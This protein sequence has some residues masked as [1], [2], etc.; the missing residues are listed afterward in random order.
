MRALVLGVTGQD[1]SYLVE[2][3]AADGYEVWGMAR[4]PNATASVPLVYGDLLDQDSLEAAL[5]TVR[6]DEIYNLAAVTSPGGA[7]GS[8]QPPLLAEVTGVGVVRL[9]EATLKCAPYA[10]VVHAS[11]SAVYDPHRYGLYGVAKAFAHEAV[12]GYRG[13][14]HCSN[15]VLFSHTSPRQDG[16]FLAPRICQAI[17]KGEPLTLGDVDSRRDW[18]SARDY[19]EA[20]QLI[21][22]ADPGEWMVATG[23]WH[24]VRDLVD[25]ALTEAGKRWEDVVSI[26]PQLPRIPHEVARQGGSVRELGWVPRTS[27]AD[28]V[29]EMV[30]A[31]A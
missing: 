20:L 2:Q 8:P 9:L 11:S 17:A 31:A 24:S 3:L 28:M 21:A 5:L 30:R 25:A 6:P 13:R 23:R 7:W 27:F 18:G 4:R 29:A 12:I 22:Q 10:R 19:C 15:A 14:L 16:R 26:D 1:G